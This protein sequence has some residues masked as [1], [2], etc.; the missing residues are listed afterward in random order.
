M[1]V[2][3]NNNDLTPDLQRKLLVSVDDNAERFNSQDIANTLLAFG[4]MGLKWRKIDRRLQAKLW[5]AVDRNADVDGGSLNEQEISNILLALG[6]KHM[7]LHWSEF[8]PDLREKLLDVVARNADAFN[9]QNISNTLLASHQLGL[10][11]RDFN[12]VLQ[13]K[14]INAVA[15]NVDEFSSQGIAMT[16][17][18]L[19]MMK[20]QWSNLIQTMQ[21]KLLDAIVRNGIYFSASSV[22]M[23]LTALVDFEVDIIDDKANASVKNTVLNAVQNQ[24]KTFNVRHI[25]EGITILDQVGF[26]WEDFSGDLQEELLNVIM[27]NKS[28]F[29]DLEILQLKMRLHRLQLPKRVH[30]YLDLKNQNVNNNTNSTAL[31]N[32]GEMDEG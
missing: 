28:K 13:A 26:N 6:K 2:K 31:A 7:G 12:P 3:W 5:S 18:A 15:R 10:D 4:Q 23:I 8:D 9:Q 22:L 20:V 1:G 21:R 19:S 32:S 17:H 29:K 11:W 16:L 24:A 25:V 14:L 30:E 27:A